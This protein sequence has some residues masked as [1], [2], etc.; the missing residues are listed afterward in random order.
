MTKVK[1]CGVTQYRNALEIADLGVD[2][3]GLNFYKQS[4][5]YISP[6]DAVAFARLLRNALGR[7]TPL[8]VGVF[9]NET[10]SNILA[11]M[12][13]AELDFV[14]LSG[15]ESDSLLKELH[16]RAFKSIQPPTTSASLE[17]VRYFSPYF[18]ADERA[19]SLILDAYHPSLRGGTGESVGVDIAKTVR[20]AVPRLMLAGGLTPQNVGDR[21]SAIAPWG[22]D[23]ASG[24]E[25]GVPGVKSLEKVRAVLKAVGRA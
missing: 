16:G 24:V 18:P 12:N 1:I 14:Q 25:D 3:L 23:I 21:V 6:L 10:A 17:D 13:S 4:P 8:L 11:V 2:M 20:D 9:V 19:P 7:K 15:D 5:R 22:V